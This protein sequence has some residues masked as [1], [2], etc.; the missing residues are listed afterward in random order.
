MNIIKVLIEF[1][2]TFVI[3]Y[4]FYYFFVIKKCKKNKKVV[5]AE[6]NLIIMLN[7]LDISKINVYEMIKVV[8]FVTSFI[9]SLIITTIW[10][11]FN[12]TIIALIFGTAISIL[13]A[14]I[15]YRIIGKYYKKQSEN[16]KKKDS[17]H[18]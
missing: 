2:V 1:I 6:V 14:I 13:V 11:F 7:N 9:I 10:I 12:N 5:P 8:S 15:C 17:H 18:T 4:L 3:V 16:N